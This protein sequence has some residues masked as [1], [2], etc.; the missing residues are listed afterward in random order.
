MTVSNR[1]IAFEPKQRCA[2][3]V[4]N[5]SPNS[6]D[7]AAAAVGARRRAT[8][9]DAQPRADRTRHPY[10]GYRNRTRRRRRDDR[11]PHRPRRRSQVRELWRV[12][13]HPHRR[14][15]AHAYI[16]AIQE[17]GGAP[18]LFPSLDVHARR[19]RAPDRPRRRPVP[20]RAGAT[21][22]PTLYAQRRAPVERPAAA[23]ARRARDRPHPA[24]P[25]ARHV[26]VLGACRGMQVL[27]V[28]LGGT[29]EQHLGDRLD[30]TPHRDDL[31]RAHVASGRPS[32]PD[33]LP[34]QHHARSRVR[35]LVASPPGRRPA[36]RGPRGVGER[37]RRRGRGDR[38][39][40]RRRSASACSGIP[41]SGSIPR[42]S[43]SSGRSSPRRAP[44]RS[45]SSRCGRSER[46]SRAR[47]VRHGSVVR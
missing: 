27:N 14:D 12:G 2:P 28:A 19:S 44:G 47:V 46:M 21:S 35:H 16:S 20:A 22:T 30:L 13:R 38:G 40:R 15:L 33:T 31:R 36:R 37:A 1:I 34:A 23:G 9:D 32:S 4:T 45:Q 42:G 39:H 10:V 41:R 25:R 5:D 8:A 7:C 3:I 6:Q 11:S 17:A 43:R 26:P 24:R 18:L 29:L